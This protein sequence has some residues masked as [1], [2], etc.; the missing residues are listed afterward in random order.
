MM[1]AW[2]YILLV[3]AFIFLILLAG[4]LLLGRIFMLRLTLA[5]VRLWGRWVAR[6]T[7]RLSPGWD[8]R[9]LVRAVNR[10]FHKSFIATPFEERILFLP[11]C[12]KPADCLGEVDRDQG[13]VC[14]WRCPE[15][16]LALLRQEALSLG[17]GHVYVVP[18]SRLMPHQGLL[19]SDQFVRAKI[20]EHDAAAAL[21]VCCDYYLRHRLIAKHRVDH[22]GYHAG[23][24]H[25]RQSVLQGVLLDSRRCRGGT[26]DWEAVRRRMSLRG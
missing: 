5:A 12:L 1:A 25:T 20:R 18:S 26:V 13:L 16:P 11:I 9:L 17:Y 15:C 4:P 14:D 8:L 10:Y 7:D 23:E 19:P 6:I 3:L 21:G 24:G 22:R 2:V